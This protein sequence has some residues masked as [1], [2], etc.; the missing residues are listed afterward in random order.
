MV[1]EMA[2]WDY[3]TAWVDSTEKHPNDELLEWAER[4]WELVSASAFN[5]TS[6]DLKYR[7]IHVMYWRRPRSG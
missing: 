1:P 3:R 7:V 4:G 6:G 2:K 5:V